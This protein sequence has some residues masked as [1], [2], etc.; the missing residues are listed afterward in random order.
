M[1]DIVIINDDLEKAYEELKAI[2][3]EVCNYDKKGSFSN[4]FHEFNTFSFFY[5]K[6]K[7]LKTPSNKIKLLFCYV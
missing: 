6:F 7:R 5:R 4:I 1:F 2:L 3:N